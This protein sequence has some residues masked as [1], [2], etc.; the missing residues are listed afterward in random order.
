MKVHSSLSK[1][2]IPPANTTAELYA[3][4]SKHSLNASADEEANTSVIKR[5]KTD[6]QDNYSRKAEAGSVTTQDNQILSAKAEAINKKFQ[7]VIQQDSE[8]WEA[9]EKAAFSPEL[10]TEQIQELKI[11][12]FE[13][14]QAFAYGRRQLGDCKLPPMKIEVDIPTPCPPRLKS[15]PY[16]ASPKTKA[17][18]DT[19][20]ADLLKLGVIRRSQSQY[21]SPVVMVYRDGKP[22]LCVNYKA[23]NDYTKP[24]RYPLPKIDE[25]LAKLRGAKYITTLDMNKGFHQCWVDPESVPLTAF[26]THAGL[27][28]YVRMPF[29]LRNAPAHFQMNMNELLG[30]ELREGWFNIYIDDGIPASETWEQHV[31]E[32][33]PRILKKAIAG[34]FTFSLA[35]SQ[36]AFPTLKALGKK[37]SGLALAIDP[38]KLIAVEK[39]ERPKNLR[40]LQA[41]LGFI[42]YHRGHL[43]NLA[44]IVRPLSYLLSKDVAWEWT[45]DREKAFQDAKTALI[46]ATELVLPDFT[47]PFRLYIDACFE[48]L[49]AEL[50]QMQEGQEK[51]VIYISRKLKPTEERYGA[52]QLEC[53][54]LIWALEKLYYY[55]DGSTFTVYTDCQAIK[56]LMEIKN[57]N[58]HMLRWQLAVQEHRGHMTV[59]HK[60]GVL[61]KAADGLSRSAIANDEDNPAADLD[62]TIEQVYNLDYDSKETTLEVA[63][64]CTLTTV[65]LAEGLHDSIRKGYES[66]I[67]LQTMIVRMSH[68]AL[69]YIVSTC[70]NHHNPF[71]FS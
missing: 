35:K 29:G 7:R 43:P 38:H 34:G 50:T 17:D 33:L 1:P 59:V 70:M 10:T 71:S 61:N 54:G 53:L 20:L 48:G 5:A 60:P 51:P 68:C 52:T 19:I 57:P 46:T 27:Y 12:L 13:N 41:F 69:Y 2:P 58:R 39:W 66:S 44:K 14:R 64:I 11:M 3:I 45:S 65:G 37:V 55:L 63:Q 16:P 28:E 23:L 31:H 42:N 49:G 6:N 24:F 9:V 8:F 40:Q 47:Q 15:A 32:H 67:S 21:A 22:R 62:P 56:A 18:I 26:T 25:T 30:T 36:F 4:N